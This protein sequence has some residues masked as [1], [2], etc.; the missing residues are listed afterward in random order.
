M[1]CFY[2]GPTS[3][4]FIHREYYKLT[5]TIFFVLRI[6]HYS[7][8]MLTAFGN[9][10]IASK[11]SF[12]HFNNDFKIGASS[13]EDLQNIAY[14]RGWD[15]CDDCNIFADKYGDSKNSSCMNRGTDHC[16][17]C[18]VCHYEM[19]HHCPWMGKCIARDNLCYFYGFIGT[20]FGGLIYA[21]VVS[22]LSI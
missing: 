22:L 20:T 1:S 19:D 11:K 10:G 4:M 15:M 7:F 21:F 14:Q 2:I 8:L 13:F 9:P 18:K 16:W 5:Y 3:D 6:F 17:R 12:D